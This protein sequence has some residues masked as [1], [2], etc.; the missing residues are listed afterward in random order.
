M[1]AQKRGR[2]DDREW[3]A[4][5]EHFRRFMRE[6]FPDL[7]KR[8]REPRHRFE[9]KDGDLIPVAPGDRAWEEPPSV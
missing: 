6:R 3:Q 7:V 5:I 9:W 4:K 2:S 1:I 8:G